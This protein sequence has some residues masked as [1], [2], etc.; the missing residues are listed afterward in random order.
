MDLVQ[1]AALRSQPRGR[2]GSVCWADVPTSPQ[3]WIKHCLL[4]RP[5]TPLLPWKDS[6]RPRPALLSVVITPNSKELP[7]LYY[8]FKS[9]FKWIIFEFV[10]IL[11]VFFGFFF[12]FGCKACGALAPRPGFEPPAPA[13]EGEIL[14]TG[15]PGKSRYSVLIH[16]S[17]TSGILQVHEYPGFS[18]FSV[19]TALGVG[20]TIPFGDVPWMTLLCLP[21]TRGRGNGDTQRRLPSRSSAGKER[22]GTDRGWTGDPGLL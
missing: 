16:L 8:F 12:F 6:G 22:R 17:W 7:I 1:G 11:F 2:R 20:T 15:P 5:E 3:C 19:R 21:G 18:G 14:T 9:F 13:L 4:L 10:T